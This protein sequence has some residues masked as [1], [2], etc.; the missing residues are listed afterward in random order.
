MITCRPEVNLRTKVAHMANRRTLPNSLINVWKSWKNTRFVDCADGIVE[1]DSSALDEV[2]GIERA[3]IPNRISPKSLNNP[4]NYK[5]QQ[6]I[7]L[8]NL[9]VDTSNQG[10]VSLYYLRKRV[11]RRIRYKPFFEWLLVESTLVREPTSI[12]SRRQAPDRR[13]HLFAINDRESIRIGPVT[14]H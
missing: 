9:Q 2:K 1:I 12:S 4:T 11:L 7:N 13:R 8:Q 14:V 5:I 10:R 6:T 3:G